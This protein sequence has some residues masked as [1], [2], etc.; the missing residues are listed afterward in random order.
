MTDT[1]KSEALK[2]RLSALEI[3]L[4]QN[5]EGLYTVFTESEPLFCYDAHSLEEVDEL[6][7]DTLTS[8]AAA[9]YGV[10]GLKVKT[11]STPAEW[12]QVRVEQVR[13]VST[14]HPVFDVA[15]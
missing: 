15:A 11:A 3:C 4:S 6:V 1:N 7:T 12:S 13:P 14:L 10:A 8:Y 9:F 2:K 5:T